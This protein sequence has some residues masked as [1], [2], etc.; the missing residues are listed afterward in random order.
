[1]LK[2]KDGIFLQSYLK[3]LKCGEIMVASKV[4]PPRVLL[5]GAAGHQSLE[6]HSLLKNDLIFSGF[7]DPELKKMKSLYK[8][9]EGALFSNVES[10]IKNSDFD[11]ALVC[12]PHNL[13]NHITL[14][15]LANKKIVIKEKP[16]ALSTSE[17]NQYKSLDYLK[18]FTIVQ[19]QYNPIFINAKQDLPLIGKVYSYQ[20]NYSLKI[21]E[22]TQGWRSEYESSRGGV[23]MDMGYHV[24]DILLSFFGE[25]SN[26][27]GTVSYCYDAMKYENLEDSISIILD[28]KKKGLHGTVNLNRH[29]SIKKEEFE[30]NGRDGTILLTP[31]QYTIFDRKGVVI[32]KF[33]N[34]KSDFRKKMIMQYIKFVNDFEFIDN[35]FNHHVKIVQLI[36]NFYGLKKLCKEKKDEKS[37][38]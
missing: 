36:E 6:Y 17:I 13:H 16:L 29:S 21:P 5:V 38:I 31:R 3:S 19:R 28:Y 23:L 9:C 7:V 30:I 27:M 35:H 1:M 32:K 11:M 8:G 14:Q 24:L 2:R 25:P 22:V 33:A 26:L 20:Y 34:E 10:A 12:V 18:F 37:K 4:I 15:L